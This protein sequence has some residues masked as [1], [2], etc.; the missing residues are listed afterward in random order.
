MATGI[1]SS[2]TSRV[3]RENRHDGEGEQESWVDKQS[4]SNC[5][6]V[7]ALTSKT[8]Q[9]NIDSLRTRKME[10][11]K[12]RNE[13]KQPADS[14][15]RCI[16]SFNG[17]SRSQIPLSVLTLPF[18]TFCP[19]F[20]GPTQARPSAEPERT[21]RIPRAQRNGLR[22]RDKCIPSNL[23]YPSSYEV[24][25]L[26]V[27]IEISFL[28]PLPV[29]H[30]RKQRRQAKTGSGQATPAKGKMGPLE[31]PVCWASAENYRRIQAQLS[32]EQILP[33]KLV[34]E[35]FLSRRGKEDKL[36]LTT[37]APQ[38]AGIQATR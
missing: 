15:Q 22:S 24:R 4:V 37:K 3:D 21:E 13:G 25:L 36:N 27:M 2:L 33:G 12:I 17:G 5:Q 1:G 32:P 30:E 7:V 8:V 19:S 34:R 10:R 35:R 14:A 11:M 20:P 9:K 29:R 31:R 28:V 23:Y 26:A 6:L 18:L 16:S 38:S